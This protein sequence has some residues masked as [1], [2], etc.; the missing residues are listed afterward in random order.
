MIEEAKQLDVN[1][2][3]EVDIDYE[4]IRDGMLMVSMSGTAVVVKD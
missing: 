2:I 3:V 4:T 1:A